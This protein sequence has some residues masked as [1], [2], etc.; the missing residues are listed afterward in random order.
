MLLQLAPIFK[1]L[2]IVAEIDS[3]EF[4]CIQGLAF[5]LRDGSPLFIWYRQQY[6]A[7]NLIFKIFFSRRQ[8]HQFERDSAHDRA[9]MAIIENVVPRTEMRA[10]IVYCINNNFSY[11]LDAILYYCYAYG[12]YP[13]EL[14]GFVLSASARSINTR[15]SLVAIY[16]AYFP[17]SW[18]EYESTFRPLIIDIFVARGEVMAA[19]DNEVAAR[20]RARATGSYI[21]AAVTETSVGVET[22]KSVV[23]VDR[24]SQLSPEYAQTIDLLDIL[25]AGADEI[26]LDNKQ[27]LTFEP[28]ERLLSLYRNFKSTQTPIL[29]ELG[30]IFLSIHLKNPIS[31]YNCNA[32]MTE[33]FDWFDMINYINFYISLRGSGT[34]KI[35][36]RTA[37]FSGN[38]EFV[39]SKHLL[40]TYKFG[41]PEKYEEE[42][43][44]TR[45]PESNELVPELE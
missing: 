42:S 21:S 23:P 20:L 9:L 7:L 13:I 24:I 10:V 19:V 29:L 36:D 4:Q 25:I 3:E 33:E 44:Y 17:I 12:I 39:Q 6:I 37:P 30:K 5:N 18:D 31:C 15:M 34:F 2:F 26:N 43:F 41:L 45:K 27:M 28:T 35:S 8:H 14:D 32:V 1:P 16:L 38:G 22:E 11:L 40:A